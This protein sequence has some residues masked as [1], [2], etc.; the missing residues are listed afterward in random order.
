M[1][2]INRIV[3]AVSLEE[4]YVLNQTRSNRVLGG[5]MWLKMS[6]R[7]INTGI[8]LSRLGLDT[9]VETADGFSIGCMCTLR[10]L[11][12]HPGL[13]RAFQNAIREAVRPI[14][15]VQFRNGATLGGSI[16]GRYGFSDLLTC[17]MALDAT[18]ELYPTGIMPLSEF[19]AAPYS[20][21]ILVRLHLNKD[22][23]KIT[24]HSQRLTRT[25][26]P[27]IAVA[28]AQKDQT[29]YIAVGA[30]PMKARLLIKPDCGLTAQSS[31][32]E[33]RAFAR[34]AATQF[35]YGSNLR[36][37]SDYR[38]HLAAVYLHRGI[39]E[40]LQAKGGA[41]HADPLMVK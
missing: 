1:P 21:E 27:V 2:M 41:D 17:L 37:S 26:F 24:Y 34:G 35:N 4:A 14:V 11:E 7:R 28:V 39:A 9:I 31:P 8:D 12:L 25:D 20:R 40:L 3:K 22:Q 19:A 13:N 30:R 10:E 38:R 16:Y 6:K 36:G 32:Q 29:L 5:F 15:G 33:L 23:R 18:V